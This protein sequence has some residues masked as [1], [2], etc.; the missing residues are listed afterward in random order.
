MSN[1]AAPVSVDERQSLI[2]I[3]SASKKELEAMTPAEDVSID[4]PP[5]SSEAIPMN[6]EKALKIA[7]DKSQPSAIDTEAF[8]SDK[9]VSIIGPPA[10]NDAAPVAIKIDKI[11]TDDRIALLVDYH[12]KHGEWPAPNYQDADTGVGLGS[13]FSHVIDR[14]VHLNREQRLALQAV[15][16]NVFHGKRGG[17]TRVVDPVIFTKDAAPKELSVDEMIA[18]VIAF[19]EANGEWPTD[20]YVDPDSG[21]G[22][23]LWFS[24]VIKNEIKLSVGQKATLLVEDPNLFGPRKDLKKSSDTP[25][26]T[27]NEAANTVIG[28]LVVMGALCASLF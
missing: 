11:S 27:S 16:A 7:A 18:R 8:V 26:D 19:R 13:F 20:A 28:F 17:H 3:D 21:A 4:L 1:Q 10:S 15:D 25:V 24:R 5:P 6:E 22:L 2:G 14:S 9:E 12:K 23:G